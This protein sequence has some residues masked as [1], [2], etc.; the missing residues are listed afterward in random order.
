MRMMIPHSG[1]SVISIKIRLRACD[2]LH[3]EAR[4]D[5]CE[6]SNKTRRNLISKD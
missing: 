6:I 5:F 3:E 4:M 1:E 2:M